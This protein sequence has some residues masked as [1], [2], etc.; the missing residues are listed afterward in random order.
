MIKSIIFISCSIIVFKIFLFILPETFSSLSLPCKW[1]WNPLRHYP[2]RR[3]ENWLYFFPF[4]CFPTC[5]H[6]AIGS[7]WGTSRSRRRDGQ[8]GHIQLPGPLDWTPRGS[9][10][11]QF[12]CYLYI[13]RDDQIRNPPKV[14]PTQI[15][16][17]TG[18]VWNWPY[19]I[20]AFT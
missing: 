9:D 13:H 14:D 10:E 11:V 2:E 19:C 15:Q 8:R 1:A 4:N 12:H 7:I 3:E 5:I 18:G 6:R 16:H 17:K 20:R